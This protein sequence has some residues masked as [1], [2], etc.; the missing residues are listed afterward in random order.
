MFTS[1]NFINMRTASLYYGAKVLLAVSLLA[2][3]AQVS[4]PTQP[5]PVTMQTVAVIL[6]ALMYAPREAC[7]ILGS[8]IIFGAAG[9]PIFASYGYG[10]SKLLGPT[11]GYLIGMFVG[12]VATS[13]VR[14]KYAIRLH[15]F[16]NSIF[17]AMIC[18]VGIYLFGVPV[19]ANYIGF[20]AAIYYGFVVFI[21]SGIIKSIILSVVL[22][23]LYD[24]NS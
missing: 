23:F 4:L 15:K 8:Y 11:G 13:Y 14:T 21:P 2:C 17:L 22:S 20:S 12:G 19:L 1:N 16:S 24:K 5:V 6:I 3:S 18:Q 9:A 10:V 7:T